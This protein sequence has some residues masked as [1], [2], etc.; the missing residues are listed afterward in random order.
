MDKNMV[1]NL[2]QKGAALAV[3]LGLALSSSAALPAMAQNTNANLHTNTST[4]LRMSNA[5]KHRGFSAELLSMNL[6]ANGNG[7]ITVRILDGRNLADGMQIGDTVT[8]NVTGDTNLYGRFGGNAKPTHFKVGDILSIRG[9]IDMD[10][11]INASAIRDMNVWMQ[12]GWLKQGTVASVNTS[13]NTVELKIR[14]LGNRTITATYS[15]DAQ[16]KAGGV[17][18]MES[19]IKVGDNIQLSGGVIRTGSAGLTLDNATSIK[20]K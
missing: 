19:D 5:F 2:P 6:N 3:A 13:T 7:T 15:A 10:G 8:L 18:G 20:I 4:H 17:D 14:K 12:S 16:V 1:M 11:E 9:S